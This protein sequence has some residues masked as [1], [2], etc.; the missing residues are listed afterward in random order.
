MTL[1]QATFGVSI[2]VLVM[3]GMSMYTVAKIKVWAMERFVSKSDFLETLH[4]WSKT[5]RPKEG[6]HARHS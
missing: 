3:Q 1:E 4:F 2:V 6:S 5:D